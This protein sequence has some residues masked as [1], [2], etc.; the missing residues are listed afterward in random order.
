MENSYLVLTRKSGHSLK[1]EV[2]QSDGTTT[3]I[4]IDWLNSNGKVGIEA[5]REVG[6]LR[7]ELTTEE[8]N[9]A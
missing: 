4:V 8:N 5:P 6:I 1:L 9:H 2:P 7:H 3:T